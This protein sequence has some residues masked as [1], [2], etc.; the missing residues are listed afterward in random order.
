MDETLPPGFQISDFTVIKLIGQGGFAYTYKVKD[1]H[2]GVWVAKELFPSGLVHRNPYGVVFCH[3]DAESQDMMS[4]AK[5]N[6]REEAYALKSLSLDSI[7]AYHRSFATNN[8]LYIVQEFIRG[9]SLQEWGENFRHMSVPERAG[10]LK[11]ILITLLET[12]HE[13]HER[14]VLHRDIKPANIM[15]R[16]HSLVPVLLDFGGARFQIGGESYNF[17][18]RQYTPGYSSIEQT[19]EGMEQTQSSDLYSLAATMLWLISGRDPQDALE[20]LQDSC[21]HFAR[22]AAEYGEKLCATLDKAYRVKSGGRYEDAQQWLANLAE[23]GQVGSLSTSAGAASWVLG[24]SQEL[25]DIVVPNATDEMSRRQLLVT[26]RSEGG[27]LLEDLSTNGTWVRES[28]GDW[29]VIGSSFFVPT[30]DVMCDFSGVRARLIDLIPVTREGGSAPETILLDLDD[31]EGADREHKSDASS[32]VSVL[33]LLSKPPPAEAV[34]N[35][36]GISGL[37]VAATF[38]QRFGAMLLNGFMLAIITTI[39]NFVIILI[40]GFFFEDLGQDDASSVVLD[41]AYLL[42][43]ILCPLL[44]YPVCWKVWGKDLGKHMI[45]LKIVDSRTGGKPALGWSFLRWLGYTV[46]AIPLLLGFFAMLWDRQKM[47]WH[48]HIAKTKVVQERS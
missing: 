9:E 36:S 23:E 20:R 2:G 17:H 18:K 26:E 43:I 44:Y 48:D 5:D 30:L 37:A 31:G 16:E 7:P 14:G 3:N 11:D 28:S 42:Q 4:I 46:S 8:T 29:A 15:L 38:G 32:Q 12:L 41:I 47:T 21:D 39:Y 6:F 22:Y 35:E 40:R 10:Q 25:A 27:Y 33:E 19:S 1:A 45:G 24:R 34:S 13:V